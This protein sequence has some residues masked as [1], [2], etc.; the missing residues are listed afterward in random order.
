MTGPEEIDTQ[1]GTLGFQSA[2]IAAQPKI[3]ADQEIAAQPKISAD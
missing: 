3:S 2:E 1:R